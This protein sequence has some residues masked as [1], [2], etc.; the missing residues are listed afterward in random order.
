M[1]GTERAGLDPTD[2]RIVDTTGANGSARVASAARA[3]TASA[4]SF[5]GAGDGANAAALLPPGLPTTAGELPTELADLVAGALD[6][7]KA[8]QGKDP[9]GFHAQQKAEKERSQAAIDALSVA[10]E[11]QED[12]H[13]AGHKALDEVATATDDALKHAEEAAGEG[14]GAAVDLDSTTAASGR[15]IA[16]ARELATRVGAEEDAHHAALSAAAGSVADPEGIRHRNRL[17][18][19]ADMKDGAEAL[20]DHGLAQ[21]QAKADE[22]QAILKGKKGDGSQDAYIAAALGL[23]Y[24][25]AFYYA[26][27]PIT[28]AMGAGKLSAFIAANPTA[29]SAAGGTGAAVGSYLGL[30][31]SDFVGNM[32]GGLKGKLKKE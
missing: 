24:A 4:A 18:R 21:V 28:A 32:L 6:S 15:E 5:G 14:G 2:P 26:A 8:Y 17:E 16:A 10:L 22:V 3:A 1:E 23:V 9:E 31:I 27:A 25:A 7:L 20:A 29:S 19:V 12:A 11:A 30:K 13:T